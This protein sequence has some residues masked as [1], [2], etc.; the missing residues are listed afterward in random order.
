MNISVYSK[1]FSTVF[2]Q[3]YLQL[4]PDQEMND[5]LLITNPYCRKIKLL[6]E[7][8]VKLHAQLI[9]HRLIDYGKSQ[10]IVTDY[11]SFRSTFDYNR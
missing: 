10:S 9:E 1:V 6:I 2:G 7:W 3:S 8:K 11:F 5:Q 4:D